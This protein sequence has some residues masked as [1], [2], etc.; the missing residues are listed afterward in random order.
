MKI[1]TQRLFIRSL[2]TGDVPL[3]AVIVSDPDVT[4]FLGDGSTHSRK[5]AEGYVKSNIESEKA[6]G[7]ARY[8]V[9]HKASGTFIG[10]CGFKKMENYTDLGWRFNPR[11]WGK[12]YATEA[13]SAVLNY[14][15]NVLELTDIVVSVATANIRSFKVA[16]KLGSKFLEPQKSD[17]QGIVKFSQVAPN[18]K[19]KKDAASRAYC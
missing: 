5:K 4:R 9:V 12:G 18:N 11:F 16:K 13:A 2:T 6:L 8:A 1:E 3:Y 19:T 10:I 7:L 14:G 17:M 15:I